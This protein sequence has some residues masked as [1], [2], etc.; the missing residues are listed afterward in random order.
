MNIFPLANPKLFASETSRHNAG[1]LFYL[2]L[3]KKMPELQLA[4]YKNSVPMNL[5][6]IA[7]KRLYKLSQTYGGEKKSDGTDESNLLILHDDNNL[8]L[9][10]ITLKFGGSAA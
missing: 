3:K 9:G 10:K 1:L 8:D 6:G 7:I 2:Y 5:N 4:T